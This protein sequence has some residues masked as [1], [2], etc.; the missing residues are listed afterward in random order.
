MTQFLFLKHCTPYSVEK[1]LKRG[2]S[3]C[4]VVDNPCVLACTFLLSYNSPKSLHVISP[5]T[6]LAMY[7]ECDFSLLNFKDKPPISK[8]HPSHYPW[9]V[10][11]RTHDPNWV[12]DEMFFLKIVK[13]EAWGASTSW[14]PPYL[15]GWSSLSRK[16]VQQKAEGGNGKKQDF[17]DI[18]DILSQVL[19]K[20][21]PS[22]GRFN[23]ISQ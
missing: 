21:D 18:V 20:A 19:P 9:L 17:G 13:K 6:F 23:H 8:I 3:K 7:F 14:Q 12:K 1:R 4:G 15:T 2:K 11:K 22:F 10:Q 16:I 5:V